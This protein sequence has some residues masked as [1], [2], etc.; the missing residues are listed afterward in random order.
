[1]TPFPHWKVRSLCAN[2]DGIAQRKPVTRKVRIS[3][4]RC[5]M[6]VTRWMITELVQQ[7]L[8]P[9]QDLPSWKYARIRIANGIEK[10]SRRHNALWQ[11]R[12]EL[13]ASSINGRTLER[14]NGLER[15]FRFRAYFE[16]SRL[17]AFGTQAKVRK[18]L[19]TR[20][21]DQSLR[22]NRKTLSG[23]PK[24]RQFPEWHL[25][26]TRTSRDGMRT[27]ERWNTRIRRH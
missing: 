13:C 22:R 19:P 8:L 27:P 14:R 11:R 9:S 25:A 21:W 18:V 17:Q 6:D 26:F 23:P 4:G 10:V 5:M 3:W 2:F 16:A 15:L 24:V 12:A 1:M 20:N 7:D